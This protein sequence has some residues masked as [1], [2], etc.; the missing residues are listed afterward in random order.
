AGPRGPSRGDRAAPA[1]LDPTPSELPD[2]R[3][4]QV[5]GARR[6]GIRRCG[7]DRVAH[8]GQS[9]GQRDDGPRRPLTAIVPRRIPIGIKTSPQA[10][11]WPTLDGAWARIG[12]HEVFDSVWMNDHLTDVS[13][14]RHGR[15]FEAL[16]TMAALV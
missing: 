3:P 14:E 7:H 12:E 4:R 11:D 10:V 1:R 6:L 5:R 16:S 15:S 13:H 8:D 2:W 9:G